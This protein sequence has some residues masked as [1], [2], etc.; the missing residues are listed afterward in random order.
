MYSIEKNVDIVI[1]IGDPTFES[2]DIA[3]RV[4][5]HCGDMD[6]DRIWTIFNKA[7]SKEIEPV[8]MESLKKK[9]KFSA[10]FITIRRY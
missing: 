7:Q 10:Q 8:M 3:E 2:F 5:K 6:I 4:A 1:I 9:S